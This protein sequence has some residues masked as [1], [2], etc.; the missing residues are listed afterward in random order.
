VG[1]VD[2]GRKCPLMRVGRGRRHLKAETRGRFLRL[3]KNRQRLW[4]NKEHFM[5][6]CAPVAPVIEE[7]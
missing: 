7:R 4:I 2:A 3:N 6:V 5:N 1:G